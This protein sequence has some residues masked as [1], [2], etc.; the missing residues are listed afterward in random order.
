[1]SLEENDKL[2]IAKFKNRSMRHFLDNLNNH[3]YSPDEVKKI[4]Q[5]LK[6]SDMYPVEQKA[7]QQRSNKVFTLAFNNTRVGVLYV[8]SR[9][10]DFKLG[11]GSKKIKSIEFYKL[12]LNRLFEDPIITDA[13]LNLQ[14]TVSEGYLREPIQFSY[15]V[16]ISEK[17][18]SKLSR[19]PEILYN[20]KNDINKFENMNDPEK[21]LDEVM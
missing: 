2:L 5:F 3:S 7:Y 20:I 19:I 1:M 8:S 4:T 16:A 12:M 17:Y 11:L 6:D 21:I 13:L 14:P 10:I 15:K 18:S 9:R